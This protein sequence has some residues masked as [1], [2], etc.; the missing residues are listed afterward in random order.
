MPVKRDT[1][2]AAYQ[3]ALDE[4]DAV[5]FVGAGLSIPAA[6]TVV[7]MGAKTAGRK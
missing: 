2:F 5:V 4:G 1:F 3:K 7:C 6:V